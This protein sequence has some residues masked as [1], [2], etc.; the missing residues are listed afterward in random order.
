MT[1]I[2]R[3]LG[4]AVIA[5]VL[6]A[7]VGCAMRAAH[8][9]VPAFAQAVSLTAG[10]VQAAFDAVEGEYA[11]AEADRLVVNYDK[12][13]F[14]PSEVKSFLPPEDLQIRMALLKGLSE[15]AN[16]LAEISSDKKLTEFDNAAKQ[17]G[18]SLQALSGSAASKLLPK[19]SDA[20]RNIA[21]AAIDALGRWF[22]ERK[23]QKELPKLV[24]QMQGPIEKIC[25]LLSA[26]IGNAPD[27]SGKGGSGLRDQLWREYDQRMMDKSAF[28]DHNKGSMDAMTRAAEIRKL[29][30]L[31][32][33]QLLAD[34]TLAQTQSG[35]KKIAATHAQLTKALTDKA[36]F[37]AQASELVSEGQRI[38]E[39]YVS[40]E[41]SSK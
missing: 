23:R 6:L 21:T 24:A 30:A 36:S 18:N 29:P 37:T 8:E 35:L 39:F 9:Q 27:P 2:N 26:D 22:I 34:K 17:F 3:R 4:L 5:L 25:D 12:A 10:N 33:Q 14:N 41:G 19:S 16:S 11:N 15:Y 32:R 28:I 31:V 38:K 13:G 7:H 20:D 1:E 40:L